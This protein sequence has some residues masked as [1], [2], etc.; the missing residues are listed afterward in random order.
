VYFAGKKKKSL[1]FSGINDFHPYLNG[2]QIHGKT[3]ESPFLQFKHGVDV[4]SLMLFRLL[5]EAS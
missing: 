1:R 3:E 4:F 2:V 5:R